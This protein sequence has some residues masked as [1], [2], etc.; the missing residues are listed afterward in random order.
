LARDITTKLDANDYSLTQLTVI[1]LLHYRVKCI[2]AVYNNKFML[3]SACVG[4][5]MIN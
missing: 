2:L 4:L 5:E 3:G 1:L